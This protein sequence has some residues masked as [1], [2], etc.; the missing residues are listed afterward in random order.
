MKL[1]LCDS[2]PGCVWVCA[3]VSGC[4]M[5]EENMRRKILKRLD[6]V[7]AAMAS[8]GRLRRNSSIDTFLLIHA[9]LR[10]YVHSF[11]G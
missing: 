9:F 7:F 8:N 5:N 3:C 4:Y 6:K 11:I 2:V 10:S 1:N